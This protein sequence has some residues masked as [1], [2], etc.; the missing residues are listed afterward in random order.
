VKF[1]Q[2]L[3]VPKA[4]KE[5][6]QKKAKVE[7]DP[8]N[9]RSHPVIGFERL[10]M[11]RLLRFLDSQQAANTYTTRLLIMTPDMTRGDSLFSVLDS[12]CLILEL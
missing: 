7:E 9:A 1:L 11:W 3:K 2:L 8:R 10:D 5:P 4:S 12:T 6:P